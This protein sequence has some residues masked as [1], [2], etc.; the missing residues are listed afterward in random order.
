LTQSF[1]S[2][3]VLFQDVSST[4]ASLTAEVV[5]QGGKPY[6]IPAGAS[7]HP[8]GGLGFACWAFEVAVQEAQLGV[9][10][11]PTLKTAG[12]KPLK[13]SKFKTHLKTGTLLKLQ[14]SRCRSQD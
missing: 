10:F 1:I 5:A 7:D 11:E 4:V 2:P 13:S 12:F 8:L 9:F 14:G 6:Y 3:L